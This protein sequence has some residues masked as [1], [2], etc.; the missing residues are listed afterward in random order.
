M[1]HDAVHATEDSASV[2]DAQPVWMAMALPTLLFFVGS[3]LPWTLA[4]IAFGVLGAVVGY[5][6]YSPVQHLLP[7]LNY[8]TTH[9]LVTFPFTL[10]TMSWSVWLIDSGRYSAFNI[11]VLGYLLVTLVA[12]WPLFAKSRK[13]S[14]RERRLPYVASYWTAITM[15]IAII[16]AG[17]IT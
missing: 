9:T 5:W 12:L 15:Y 4:S 11:V 2:S 7:T 8:R 16:I 3:V 1:H 17:L 10:L 13:N 14:K 6:S